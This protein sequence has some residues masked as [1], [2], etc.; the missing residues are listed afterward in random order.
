MAISRGGYRLLLEETHR[1]PFQGRIMEL[2]R[3][4]VYL[5]PEELAKWAAAHHVPLKPTEMRPSNLQECREAGFVDDVT[6][7]SSLGF[8]AVDSCDISADEGPSFTLDLNEPVPLSFHGNYDAVIDSG[9]IEHIFD[10]KTVLRNIHDMLKPNGRAVFMTVPVSNYVDHGYYMFSPQILY[11]YFFVNKYEI[12]SSYVIFFK[13]DFL[14]DPWM[15]YPYAPGVLD[16]YSYG[17]MP[18]DFM[19][20]LWLCV[21]KTPDSLSGVIPQQG[22]SRVST[23]ELPEFKLLA[24]L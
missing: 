22:C 18:D 4:T 1:R 20:S 6:L 7:F 10:L 8:D 9:T 23:V 19:V 13:R 5:S 12:V 16:K 21:E 15:I 14:K 17:A 3:N 11:D 24:Q 2:G